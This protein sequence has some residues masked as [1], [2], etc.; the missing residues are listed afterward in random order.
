MRT[1]NR[2]FAW[3]YDHNQLQALVLSLQISEH[4][5][6]LLDAGCIF[7]KTRLPSYGHA[8][9]VAYALQL[10]SEG[11]QGSFVTRTLQGKTRYRP[12]AY[13]NARV[14]LL[15]T[16]VPNALVGQNC[17]FCLSFQEKLF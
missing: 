5:L 2:R 4:W 10:L 7:T 9:V 1:V 15:A 11:A 3:K 12:H 14:K 13:L 8:S 6:D 16:H 17:Q